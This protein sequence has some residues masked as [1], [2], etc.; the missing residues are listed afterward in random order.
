MEGEA[1]GEI[2][3]AEILRRSIENDRVHSAYLFTGAG[4]LPPT[5]ARDFARFGELYLRDGVTPAGD[6]I[7]PE[8]WR[9]HGVEYV[10]H[11]PETGFGYGR[12]WWR[13]RQQERRR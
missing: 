11:D 8:G 12:H 6:R 7:L 10:S 9:D 4:A 3:P 5:T 1:H 13:Y 2:D